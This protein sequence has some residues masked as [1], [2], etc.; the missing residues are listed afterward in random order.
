MEICTIGKLPLFPKRIAVNL[1][2]RRFGRCVVA[3]QLQSSSLIVSARTPKEH[4][5][6][7]FVDCSAE[8]E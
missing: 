1:Q 8:R 4:D 5:A 7:V 6:W 2:V 3:I